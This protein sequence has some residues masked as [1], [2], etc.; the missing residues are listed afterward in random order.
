M[1]CVARLY[2]PSERA[3][4][5]LTQPDNVGKAFL[6]L[7]RLWGGKQTSIGYA[8]T[9]VDLAECKVSLWFIGDTLDPDELA[10]WLGQPPAYQRRKGDVYSSKDGQEMVARTGRFQLTTGWR[11]GERMEQLITE[12]LAKV[13]DDDPLWERINAK[14]TGEIVCGVIMDS[15]NEETVLSADTLLALGRRGLSLNLDIYDSGDGPIASPD[16]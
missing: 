12:L 1:R 15:A 13:P 4:R 2:V 6:R 3:G 16:G 10:Q 5:R 14:M 11:P 9:M 7:R 8:R